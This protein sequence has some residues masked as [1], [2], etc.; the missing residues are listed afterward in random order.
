MFFGRLIEYGR[1]NFLRLSLA[2]VLVASILLTSAINQAEAS[3]TGYI[4]AKEDGASIFD[5][6]TGTIV[7]VGSLKLSQAYKI[8]ANY[9]ADYW[10][11]QF[12]NGYGYVRKSQTNTATKPTKEMKVTHSNTTVITKQNKR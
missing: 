11:I 8:Y 2:L 10:Q 1:L 4:G 12:G 3:M 6:R 9:D 5:N 7:Q